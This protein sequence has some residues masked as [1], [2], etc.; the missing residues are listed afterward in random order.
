MAACKSKGTEPIPNGVAFQV[1]EAEYNRLLSA[2]TSSAPR[3]FEIK[4]IKRENDI[5]KIWVSGGCD[6]SNYKVVWDGIM[7]KSYPLTVFLV[8]TLE[9][10]TG[11]ECA[12]EMDHLLEINLKEKFGAVYDTQELH[13]LLSNGSKVFDKVVDPKG[14]VSNK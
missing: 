5:L 1:N 7:R 10:G 2:R 9:K 4:D 8:V 11:V 14:I 6:K 3:H 13:I 12:A